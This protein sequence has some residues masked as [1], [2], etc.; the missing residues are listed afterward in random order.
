M[1]YEVITSW[2]RDG[3]F[4]AHALLQ[5]GHIDNAAAFHQWA[6][7]VILQYENKITRCIH[8]TQLGDIPPANECLHSRFTVEGIEVPGNW[9]HHQLD[10][11]G[12]WLWSLTEFIRKNTKREVPEEWLLA[13]RLAKDYLI[14]LWPFPCSDS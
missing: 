14:S 8:A 2:F 3:S 10:G 6:S 13:S 9:G 4:C 12:T 11:V 7:Q 1:L 5:A